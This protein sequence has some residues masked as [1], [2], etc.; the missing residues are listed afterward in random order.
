MEVHR[1]HPKVFIIKFIKQE[2][3]FKKSLKQRLDFICK[4]CKTKPTFMNDSIIKMDKTTTEYQS[5]QELST[6]LKEMERKLIT[7]RQSLFKK[8]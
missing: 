6:T 8:Q 2:L 1:N 7:N 5:V 3:P 4:N